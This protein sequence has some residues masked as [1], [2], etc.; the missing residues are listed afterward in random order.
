MVTG[1]NKNL[2]KVYNKNK[3]GIKGVYAISHTYAKLFVKS[4][5]KYFVLTSR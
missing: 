2:K 4:Q 5:P 1:L 3:K